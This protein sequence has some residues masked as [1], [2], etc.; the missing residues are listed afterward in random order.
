MAYRFLLEVPE[1]LADDANT[2]VNNVPDAQVLLTRDSHGLGFEDAFVDL[3]VAAHSFVV[4]EAIY[5]WLVDSG[6]PYP[7][8]RLLLHDGRRVRFTKADASLVIA[9]IRRDQPWVEHTMPMIGKHE[10]PQWIGTSSVI[11]QL[12]A[13]R[14]L[15]LDRPE[16][17]L[18]RLDSAPTIAVH[19]LAPA[20]QFYNEVLDLYV[21]ARANK[22]ENGVM[23]VIEKDYAPLRARLDDSEADYVFLENGPLRLNL[24]RSARGMPL[25]YG[26]NPNHVRTT[27]TPEQ[28][29]SIKGRILMHGYNLLESSAG[30]VSFAD[31][32]NTLWL[33]SPSDTAAANLSALQG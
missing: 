14:N 5:R 9:A 22:A 19:N 24:Q 11:E 4:I 26:T 27:A 28:I 20:E 30:T 6:Q 3:S 23:D 16:S 7:D 17:L 21:V 25:P 29:A 2:V 1:S 31:P 18:D 10:P 12:E 32:F 13:S 8:I 33:I 15:A